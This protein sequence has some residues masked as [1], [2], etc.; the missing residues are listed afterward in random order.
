[1]PPTRYGEV[2]EFSFHEVLV[3]QRQKD[4]SDDDTDRVD[5]SPGAL[6]VLCFRSSLRKTENAANH[7]KVPPGL[8]IS[9][10]RR[11]MTSF[12][13]LTSTRDRAPTEVPQNAGL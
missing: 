5:W 10:S 12:D 6:N 2:V 7:H 9:T 13:G 3:L 11:M 8:G 1:M 4:R